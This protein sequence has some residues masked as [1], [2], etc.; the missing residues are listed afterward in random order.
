MLTVFEEKMLNFRDKEAC[1]IPLLGMFVVELAQQLTK[2]L[3][4]EH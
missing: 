3:D 1:G 4:A 2:T